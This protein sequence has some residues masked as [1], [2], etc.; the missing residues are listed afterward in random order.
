MNRLTELLLW[1]LASILPSWFVM[2]SF[3]IW[4]EILDRRRKQG[5]AK[6]DTGSDIFRINTHLGFSSSVIN[7]DLIAFSVRTEVFIK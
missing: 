1:M 7:V 2:S 5:A 6:G 4:W 3:P